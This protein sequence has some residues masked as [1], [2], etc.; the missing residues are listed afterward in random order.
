MAKGTSVLIID[1]DTYICHILKKYLEQNGYEADAVFSGVAAKNIIE[2]KNF[3]LVLSDFRLPDSDGLKILQHVKLKNPSVPVIIMTAYAEIKKAVELIKSGAFDYITKPIQPE[4]VLRIIGGAMAHSKGRSGKVS[5]SKEFITGTSQE[6]QQVMNYVNVVAPTD[7]T[8]IIEGETGSGKEYI[9]RAIHYASKRSHKPFIAVDCGAIPKELANS[10]L[11]GHIKGAFTGAVQDKTGYFE[12]ARGGTLFLDEVG[13]LPHEIQMK[14]LRALQERVITKTGGNKSIK[15]DVRLIT[16]VNDNLFKK[17]RAGEFREDLY[18]R[19]NGFRI[20]LP[21]LRQ[22]QEDI[23]EFAWFFIKQANRAF[24]KNVAHIDSY[25]RKLLMDYYW[26]GNIRELQNVINR[27]VLLSVSD[28]IT[29]ELIPEEIRYN[30][31]KADNGTDIT[32]VIDDDIT[33]LKSAT[34]ITEKEIIHNAL[35]KTN[36]N[37]SKAARLLNI[38]RKTLYNKIKLYDL[39]A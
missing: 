16:A 18:H 12:E 13:N 9:A 31:I 3:D 30:T 36:N 29:P 15:V 4:E 27:I 17:V 20:E 11:F 26:H 32:D 34:L 39:D 37:K 19:L 24:N 35:V 23:M 2:K 22:R 14:I 7:I 6:I 38:D 33:D 1:D 5:F 28:T 8:V 25:A 21:A 10:V